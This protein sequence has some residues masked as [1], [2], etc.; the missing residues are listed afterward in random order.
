VTLKQVAVL[1]I[2]GACLMNQTKKTTPSAH[3]KIVILISK[4]GVRP[5]GGAIPIIIRYMNGE[6]TAIS[7]PEPAK[8]RAVHLLIGRRKEEPQEVSLGR[9]FYQKSGD[10]E[11]WT[12]EDAET[13]T[14]A[15]GEQYEFTYDAGQ[16]WPELFALGANLVQLKDRADEVRTVFSNT[17][18]ID[19][20]YDASTFPR[21]LEILSSEE[22]TVDSRE[23]AEEWIKKLHPG[24]RAGREGVSEARI[25]WTKHEKDPETLKQMEALNREP[26]R[27][28]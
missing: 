15:P 13:I 9:V 26:A 22:S 17:L 24:F 1:A 11:R 2:L 4:S 6:S 27:S 14:L 23:F 19:V 5:L 20:A 3:G 8:T 21:L 12:R 25:W 16:R 10:V 18:E 28:R 7:F